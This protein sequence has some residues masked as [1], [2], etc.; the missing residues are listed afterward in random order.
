MPRQ[1]GPT[2][3]V[4]GLDFRI[5]RQRA[6]IIG[7]MDAREIIVWA[8]IGLSSLTALLYA[9]IG[10]NVVSLGE[11]KPEEQKAFGVPATAVFAAGAV[12]ALI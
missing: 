4:V 3:V 11:I 6:D 12:V 10:L 2:S 8:A 7:G 1:G 5:R 9:L